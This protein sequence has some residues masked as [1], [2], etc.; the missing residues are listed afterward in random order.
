MRP[1]FKWFRNLVFLALATPAA[2]F[3][4]VPFPSDLAPAATVAQL[5]VAPPPIP[6]PAWHESRHDGISTEFTTEFESPLKTAVEVNNR[7]PLTL[8]LPSRRTSTERLPVVVVL[9]YLGAK[10]LRAEHALGRELNRR[11]VA[12]ALIVLPY[13]LT[14]A[15]EGTRS[16]ELAVQPDVDV[17]TSTMVQSARDV[18]RALQVLK[19]RDDLDP[20]EF[21]VAGIS[22]GSLVA[23]LVF[24]LE[25]G[26]VRGGFLLGGA[27]LAHILWTSSRVIVSRA[28]LRADGFTEE[29]LKT[30]LAPIEPETYLLRRRAERPEESS[31]ALAIGGRF[32]SVVPP[33]AFRRLV[34]ALPNPTVITLDTGHYGGI[35]VQQRLLS[36]VAEYFS[37]TSFGRP[38]IA[39]K[40]IQAPTLRLL[41]QAVTPLGFDIGVGI[42]LF[43]TS[44]EYQTFGSFV[45]TA[46][47]VELFIGQ[48]VGSGLAVGGVAGT[49]GLAAGIFWS[50]VL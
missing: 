43:R 6:A 9:H 48:A 8:M 22:L 36:E 21:G 41:A 31:N 34:Q 38:Y 29:K 44:A 24:G 2:T 32:D 15:P 50:S 49:R 20:K 12:A 18:R 19:T 45:V 17:L 30:A 11:G 25:P 7:V 46:R 26:F 13:H 40:S 1:N 27:D 5:V 28:Q 3:A 33:A 42:D 47:G 10:D 14:R 4:Q 37:N 39:P 16:G 23:E 35:F